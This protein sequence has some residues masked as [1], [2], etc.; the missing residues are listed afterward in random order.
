ME[1]IREYD[2]DFMLYTFHFDYCYIMVW[3]Y[4]HEEFEG[5][6]PHFYIQYIYYTENNSREYDSEGF[7]LHE[8]FLNLRKHMKQ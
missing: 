3:H 6:V 1:L 4:L 2:V 5:R 8:A 7:S